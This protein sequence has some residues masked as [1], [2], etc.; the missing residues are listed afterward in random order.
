[1]CSK[2]VSSMLSTQAAL[3]AVHPYMPYNYIGFLSLFIKGEVQE[4][5]TNVIGIL[6]CFTT[7][8]CLLQK[9]CESLTWNLNSPS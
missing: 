5:Y 6:L 7:I 9:S 8:F 2:E 4:M 1:M 3:F